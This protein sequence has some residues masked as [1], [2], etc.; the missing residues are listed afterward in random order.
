[1]LGRAYFPFQTDSSSSFFLRRQFAGS[2]SCRISCDFIYNSLSTV[3]ASSSSS[4]PVGMTVFSQL[5]TGFTCV[6]SIT[7]A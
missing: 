6:F 1:M 2:L 5:K 7:M 3:T 4:F